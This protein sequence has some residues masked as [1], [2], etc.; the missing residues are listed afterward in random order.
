M[1]EIRMRDVV[2]D[3]MEALAETL[4]ANDILYVEDPYST[5]LWVTTIEF[6]RVIALNIATMRSMNFM[7]REHLCL[8]SVLN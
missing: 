3:D 6:K 4:K 8:N 1:Y 2:T 5:A 7:K